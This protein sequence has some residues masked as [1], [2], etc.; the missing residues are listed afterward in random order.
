MVKFDRDG[1]PIRAAKPSDRDRARSRS[2]PGRRD[3][4]PPRGRDRSRSPPRRRNEDDGPRRRYDDDDRRSGPSSRF[5]GSRGRDDAGP[6]RA[7]DEGRSSGGGQRR[8]EERRPAAPEVR[9]AEARPVVPAGMPAPASAM[10]GGARVTRMIEV[11]ANDRLGGKGP[12]CRCGHAD[13]RSPR[14]MQPR[15]HH[16]RP[17]EAHRSAEGHEAGEGAPVDAASLIGRSC[18]RSGTRS[19]RTTFDCPTTR[20]AG[21]RCAEADWVD[22]RRHEVRSASRVRAETAA[23]RCTEPGSC[24]LRPAFEGL[25]TMCLHV[26]KIV[27]RRRH[28]TKAAQRK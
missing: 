10:G 22:S 25:K 21:R 17:Q 4:S 16:R 24:T 5:D 27:V 18:S 23:W 2:P 15:R 19:S 12:F 11:I 6:S 28:Q 7:R 8:D 3:R 9:Y 26:E 13:W 20:C 1:L 14:Q